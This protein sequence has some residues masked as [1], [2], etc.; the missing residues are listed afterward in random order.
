MNEKK[1]SG[2]GVT[3]NALIFPL[4]VLLVVLHFFIVYLIVG[5]NRAEDALADLMLRSGVCQQTATNLQAGSSVLSETA[6][7]YAQMPVDADGAP[8][9]GP[10]TAYAEELGNARRGEDI[11]AQFRAYDVSDAVRASIEDAAVCSE[12][13]MEIQL[14]VIALVRSIYP[15]PPIPT[16]DA[17][18]DVPLTEE[19]RAM[20]DEARLALARRLILDAG[21]SRLKHTLSEDIE[22]CHEA[23]QREL[24]QASAQTR[25]HI[26]TL[27]TWLWAVVFTIIGTLVGTF[28]LYYQWLI[29][30][31]R[32]YARQISS[33]EA[34]EQ[35]SGIREMRLMVS[36]YNTLLRRRNRLESI[37]RAAAETD[38][39]TGLP[40]RA[41]F[42]RAALDVGEED[43]ALA[44]VMFDVNYLKQVN[45][46]QGHLAGDRLLRTA[47]ECIRECFGVGDDS[48]CYRIGG[49]EFAAVLRP[50]GEAEL[51]P[52]LDRF[53][54]ALERENISVSYGCAFAAQPDEAGFRAAIAEADRRMY[55]KKKQIH[56]Q[57]RAAQPGKRGA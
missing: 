36:A 43:G 39:L 33:D 6:T 30:P 31:L 47:A 2:G 22:A 9:P 50:C 27:R 35:K 53:D 26:D 44:L 48:N 54:L 52:R 49:D 20:P 1:S 41:G 14:H 13:M 24:A 21:Y 40:N 23:I 10:L 34:M 15:L 8:N 56:G 32:S 25:Q 5:V 7:S 38:A 29:Y 12:Q 11:A 16:L 3:A 45:D 57:S 18:P 55:E 46:T 42:E 51:A 37:L 17:I 19:E 4:L 28:L